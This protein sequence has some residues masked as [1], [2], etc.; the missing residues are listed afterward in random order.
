MKGVLFGTKHSYDDFGLVLSSKSIPLPSPKVIKVDVRGSDGSLDLSTVITGG[1]VKYDNCTLEFVFT[2]IGDW[3]AAKHA[4]AAHLHG[5][6]MNIVLD[7]DPTHYFVGRA[8]ID[9][10]KENRA[11]AE[12]VVTVDAE[13]WRYEA[14]ETTVELEATTTEK[15]VTLSNLR[16]WVVP[17]ITCSDEVTITYDGT[18]YQLQAGES[19]IPAILLKE[20]NNTLK[21]KTASGTAT[22]TVKYRKA[23]L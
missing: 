12:I 13:P 16:R 18:V 23:I 21:Y 22:V 5:R 7:N 9:S 2:A 17:T 20:G 14:N 10:F 19:I 4:F 8:S 1:D 11:T 6:R 3:E 15:T